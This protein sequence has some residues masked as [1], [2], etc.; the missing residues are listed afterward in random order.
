M[1]PK[2]GHWIK[3]GMVGALGR[4]MPRGLISVVRK[5]RLRRRDRSTP[6]SGPDG[7]FSARLHPVIRTMLPEETPADQHWDRI[8]AAREFC[9]FLSYHIPPNRFLNGLSSFSSLPGK[10][11]DALYPKASLAYSLWEVG[12]TKRSS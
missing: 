6:A 3:K 4:R 10:P 8:T 5:S 9:M 2:Q 7:C 1:Q 11:Q 12:T